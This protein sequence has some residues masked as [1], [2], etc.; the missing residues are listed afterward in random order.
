MVVKVI[1][2]LKQNNTN[3][4]IFPYHWHVRFPKILH[5]LLIYSIVFILGFLVS[6]YPYKGNSIG[7]VLKIK[8]NELLDIGSASGA[9]NNLLGFES[10]RY[11]FSQFSK[12]SKIGS[13]QVGMSSKGNVYA[14]E[15]NRGDLIYFKSESLDDPIYVGNL[16][17]KLNLEK[18]TGVSSPPLVMDLHIFGSTLLFS[19]VIEDAIL[20]CQHLSL[21]SLENFPL[22]ELLFPKII[23]QTPCVHDL[24]NTV[25]WG[26]RISSS[27][28]SVF[29][30]IGEQRYDRSGFPK[31]IRI[32]R[33]LKQ[34]VF[35]SVLKF[36]KELDSWSVYSSGLRNAQGLFWDSES[37]QLFEAE[38]GPNGGDEVN[39]LKDGEYFGWPK[40]TYGKPYP[41]KYPS[42][43]DEVGQSN[44]PAIG[45]DLE[46]AKFGLSSGSH[47]NYRSPLF[48][49]SP[50]VGAGNLIRVPLSS[51]LKEWR[52]DILVV[53]M[54]SQKLHRLR[55]R[56]GS[57]VHDE[58]IELSYRIR[59]LNLSRNGILIF[60][61]DE[62]ALFSLSTYDSQVAK[63]K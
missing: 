44:N 51:P 62:G 47:E 58:E 2:Q 15:R 1:A 52:G 40:E 18:S 38:H 48:S 27:E 53:H 29:L 24:D 45:V 12:F 3:L 49:W 34:N 10:S 43:L 14:L 6:L 35:G 9:K 22:R 19:I 23:F 11:S 30:S 37:N 39:L 4:R 63:S 55:L 36:S 56:D 32:S 61:T 60:S 8:S 20:K 7:Q 25:M 59:D 41:Q 5:L 17:E 21:Y 42:G 28:E 13:F 46:L 57:V 50:G 33:L 26:G 16:F 54:G 31:K